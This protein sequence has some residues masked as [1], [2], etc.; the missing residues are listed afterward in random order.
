MKL[1]TKIACLAAVGILA[2]LP[3]AFAQSVSIDERFAV[4]AADPANYL[5]WSFGGKVTKDRYDAASGASLA[6]TTSAINAV[7]YDAPTTKKAAI[8]VGLWGLLLYPG[9]DYATA[10][11][12]AFTATVSGKV[13]TIH[14]IHRGTAFELVTDN[15][16]KFNLSSGAKIAKGLADNV[17]GDFVLKKEFVKAGGDPQKMA[18]LDWSKITLVPDVR[19]PQASRW[20]EGSLEMKVEKGVLYVKGNLT[21]KKK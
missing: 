2:A 7:R 16:G 11:A 20:Y 12:D 13:V 3:A 1:S 6:G 5:N 9:S 21:E 15:D 8:P 4:S 18:D 17:G 14:F 10:T 19:S